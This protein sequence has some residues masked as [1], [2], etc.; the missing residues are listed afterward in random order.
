MKAVRKKDN[1]DA[2]IAHRS[3]LI[4]SYSNGEITKREFL[5]KN[6]EYFISGNAKPFIKID[7]Y[8]KGMYNYQYFNGLA[9]YYKMMARE[10]RNTKKH[11]KYYNY[12]LN[13]GQ[14][15][16][17][18]K[19]NS[20]ID[21][22]KLIDF[23]NVECYFINC[24]SKGLEGELF[25]IV[26]NDKK[27]AIFHSKSEDILKLCKENNVFYPDKRDSLISEYINEKY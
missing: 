12:Y 26:L 2:F 21:I 17:E 18:E 10:V 22:L 4:K 9:K 23:K 8:E 13:L 11:S 19:D 16:Y 7:L 24:D 20:V 3:F 27:E 15:Y 6:Y 25:E 1:F 5:K 14:K